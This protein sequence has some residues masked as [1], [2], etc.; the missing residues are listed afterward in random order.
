MGGAQ[1]NFRKTYQSAV[2]ELTTESCTLTTK[3]EASNNVVIIDH[4]TIKGDVEGVTLT[5]ST[6]GTC[7]LVDN[8]GDVAKSILHD[9][10]AQTTKTDSDLF[11]DFSFKVQTNV[12]DVRQSTV[13]NIMNVFEGTCSTSQITSTNNN[14]VY[15]TDSKLGGNFKGVT[16][17][18]DNKLACTLTNLV[19]TS[20]YNAASATT[21]QEAHARGIA[22]VV[23]AGVVVIIVVM[24]VGYFGVRA[25]SK[26]T[27]KQGSWQSVPGTESDA[28]SDSGSVIAENE[29]KAADLIDGAAG[30]TESTPAL[31]I[32]GTV[33]EKSVLGDAKRPVLGDAKRPDLGDAKRPVLGKHKVS[34]STHHH[35][36][37]PHT[38]MYVPATPEDRPGF[39]E[40]VGVSLR[41]SSEGASKFVSSPDGQKAIL[42]AVETMAV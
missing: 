27:F 39:L 25:V 26:L 33:H 11:G 14:F 16:N 22:A 1:S 23:M 24:A 19:K 35:R 12:S 36:K 29:N 34:K 38:A 3:A 18:S 7:V 6:D 17:K 40:N 8:V 5:A 20:A 21:N 4:S 31:G 37:R 32:P 15:I 2:S 30:T 28:G 41:T 9:V 10:A 42:K 13:N